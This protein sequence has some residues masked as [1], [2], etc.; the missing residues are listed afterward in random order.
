MNRKKIPNGL[1]I[2]K[3]RVDA[4]NVDKLML[5]CIY[6]IYLKKLVM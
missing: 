1:K 4:L 2:L 5:V 6:C 3:S